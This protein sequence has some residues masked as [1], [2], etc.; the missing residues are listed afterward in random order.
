MTIGPSILCN[1][2]LEEF[3]RE[4]EIIENAIEKKC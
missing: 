3:L 1:S 2:A 4:V